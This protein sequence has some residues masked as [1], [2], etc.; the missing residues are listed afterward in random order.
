MVAKQS[1]KIIDCEEKY[2]LYVTVSGG[3][4]S[5]QAE[6]VRHGIARAL[7]NEAPDIK[8]I[9]RRA[10]LITRDSRAVERKKS[11]IA[12]SAPRK[13]IFQTLIADL[14]NALQTVKGR[15]YRSRRLYR[16][17]IGVFIIFPSAVEEVVF[18]SRS[19]GDAVET[20][21]PALRSHSKSHFIALADADLTSCDAVFCATPPAVAMNI[22]QAPLSSG[23]V[24]IDLSPDFRL[25]ETA[26]YERWY[27]VKHTAPRTI[28]TSGL[29]PE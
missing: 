15:R 17:R 21:I 11:R 3:G 8:S 2:D 14:G 13:A 7:V 10:G 27:G 16:C 20:K 22:V 23:T 19:G 24:V 6:A 29:W 5:G 4:E 1:L 9:F 25:R 28:I 12:K 18:I 26:L